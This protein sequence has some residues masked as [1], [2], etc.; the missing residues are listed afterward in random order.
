ME[1]HFL[2]TASGFP[3]P[4]RGASGLVLKNQLNG[5]QWLF[6]CGEGTQIAAQKSDKIKVG[7]LTKIFISHTHG[8]H[9]YG[10]PGLLCTVSQKFSTL[11]NPDEDD[12]PAANV[13]IYGPEGLRRFLRIALGMSQ[14]RLKFK[15]TVHELI[16]TADKKPPK[17]KCMC[18]TKLDPTVDPPLPCE[19]VGRDIVVSEDGFWHSIFEDPSHPDNHGYKV[20]AYALK[21]TIPCLGWLFIEPDKPPKLNIEKALNFGVPKGP[22]L[23]ELKKGGD[24]T[25]ENGKVV[26]SQDVLD[27]TNIRGRRIAILGD[28]YDS[29]ELLKLARKLDTIVDVIVHEATFED[30]LAEEAVSK[31]HSTPKY[32]TNL[33]AKLDT[34]LLVLTHFSH[35]YQPIEE[36][37]QS[38]FQSMPQSFLAVDEQGRPTLQILLND[39]K[40]NQ[41]FRGEVKLA[42]DFAVIHIPNMT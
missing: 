30:E 18:S 19:I 23:A 15:Y 1:L 13:E 20:Y 28:T 32:V 38:L 33:A 31:G 29:E 11:L 24:V 22:L 27:V 39:A 26:K 10:L 14:S 37:G 9:M 16:F 41:E 12:E 8:D 36:T 17:F 6:D 35:R 5:T 21:H 25:L 40:K 2:G 34:R 42:D 3:S 4:R 7:K